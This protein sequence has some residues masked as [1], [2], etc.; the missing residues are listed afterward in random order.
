MPVGLSSEDSE[1]AEAPKV[2]S[3]GKSWKEA[4]WMLHGHRKEGQHQGAEGGRRGREREDARLR[5]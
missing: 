4:G 2:D 1:R 5:K 3:H